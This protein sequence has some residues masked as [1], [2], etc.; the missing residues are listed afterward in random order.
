MLRTMKSLLGLDEEDEALM[1]A[2]ENPGKLAAFRGAGLGA[3]NG[4]QD[5]MLTMSSS[6]SGSSSS[7]GTRGSERHFDP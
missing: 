2:G 6:G 4:N 3:R 1:E 5:S 7:F